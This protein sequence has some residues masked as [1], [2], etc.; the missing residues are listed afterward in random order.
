MTYK[1]LRKYRPRHLFA[2][3]FRQDALDDS[4]WPNPQTWDALETYLNRRSACY[5]AIEGAL[6]AWRAFARSSK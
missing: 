6:V 5:G 3:D 2:Q 4:R 1:W